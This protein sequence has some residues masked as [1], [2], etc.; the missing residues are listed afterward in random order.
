MLCVCL[1][2]IQENLCTIIDLTHFQFVLSLIIVPYYF[3]HLLKPYLFVGIYSALKMYPWNL[4]MYFSL[5]NYS[6]K[7]FPSENFLEGK[8][9]KQ[10]FIIFYMPFTLIQFWFCI[11]MTLFFLQLGNLSLLPLEK[12]NSFCWWSGN[13]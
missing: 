3:N 12:G 13:I 10:V 7:W 1:S 6:E 8:I 2:Y 5:V 11:N 4:W 9:V